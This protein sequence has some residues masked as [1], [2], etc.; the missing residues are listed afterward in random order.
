MT[1][2]A[3]AWSWTKGVFVLVVFALGAISLA[4][5]GLGLAPVAAVGGLGALVLAAVE[6]RLARPGPAVLAAA[7]LLGWATLSMTWSAFDRRA[8]VREP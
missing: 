7:A 6:R 3:A 2:P 5:G 8:V 4:A 1:A